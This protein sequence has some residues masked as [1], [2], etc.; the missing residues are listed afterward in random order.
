MLKS[1]IQ[2][3]FRQNGHF[4]GGLHLL[5]LTGSDP[6]LLARLQGY[7][8]GQW[9]PDA[10]KQSLRAALQAWLRASP[11]QNP[12]T[13]NQTGRSEIPH[14]RPGNQKPKTPE[15]AGILALRA[16]A[17][18]LHKRHA[19]LKGR[20]N[21]MAEDADN[22]TDAQRA[23]VATRIMAEVIPALD[24]IYDRIRHWKAT[25]Q[26]PRPPKERDIVRETVGKMNRLQKILPPRISKL[27]K[28]LRE[29]KRGG[30]VL[31]E[32]ELMAYK[33]ELLEK[34]TEKAKLEGD[35]GVG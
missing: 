20:L 21:L 35:L 27:R 17:R 16:E 2:S 28:Y 13:K 31:S 14:R 30:K 11:P 34:E 33:A 29:G 23:E 25:G 9:V 6:R 10:A 8:H 5:A 22:Y 18:L 26:A 1:K 3:W 7:L 24:G 19:D 32:Q 12:K 15:P 4:A